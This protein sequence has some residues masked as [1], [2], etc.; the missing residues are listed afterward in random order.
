MLTQTGVTWN[1]AA[2]QQV[3]SG[4]TGVNLEI[5]FGTV[6]SGADTVI[7][8]TMN[9]LTQAGFV[10]AEYQGLDGITTAIID[11]QNDNTG[12]S[13]LAQSGLSG[14]TT[15]PT[16]MLYVAWGKQQNGDDAQF[17]NPTNDLSMYRIGEGGSTGSTAHAVAAADFALAATGSFESDVTLDAVQNW[18][19]IILTLEAEPPDPPVVSNQIPQPS[20]T[21]DR[22]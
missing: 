22:S 19:A 16:Q 9:E 2:S 5:W 8:I 20:D 7:N 12:N 18:V 21:C 4:T 14:T 3:G 1:L 15:T 17:R 10:V 11:Q 13:S 6:S